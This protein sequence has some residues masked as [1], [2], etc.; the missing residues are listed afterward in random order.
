M[1][2]DAADFSTLEDP[3]R[4]AVLE[5]LVVGVIADGQIN[6]AESR[7]FDELVLGLPWGFDREVL[8]VMIQGA[9]ERLSG[10]TT[11]VEIHD[12]L[13][14]LAQRL[15]SE[16]LREKVIFTMATLMHSD[17]EFN[18]AEKNVVGAVAVAFGIPS[19]RV[20]AINDA[21]HGRATPS[22]T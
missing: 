10:L 6:A 22:D 14:K 8:R 13:V 21:L 20:A 11:P 12:Y 9:H 3:E 1:K 17:G 5:A 16:S 7:H 2:L 15:P 4:L 18:R 19:D